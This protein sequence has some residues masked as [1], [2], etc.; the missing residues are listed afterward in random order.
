MSIVVFSS[1]SSIIQSTCSTLD[2]VMN[3]QSKSDWVAYKYDW[4]F[5]IN[6]KITQ[7]DQYTSCFISWLFRVSLSSNT[8]TLTNPY[9]TKVI[10]SSSSYL[11]RALVVLSMTSTEFLCWCMTLLACLIVRGTCDNWCV[12]LNIS[13]NALWCCWTFFSR[14]WNRNNRQG[15]IWL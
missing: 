1:L 8:Q 3:R 4:E 14:H 10:P 12:E 7:W 9:M 15:N 13:P 5:P 6:K 11:S 2:W